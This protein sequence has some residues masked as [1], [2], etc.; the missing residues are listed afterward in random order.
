MNLRRSLLVALGIAG[1]LVPAAPASA[2]QASPTPAASRSP[3]D[4]ARSIAARWK[5]LLGLSDEQ[6]ARFEA[7]ALTAEK[8]TAEAR[9]AAAGDA[10]KFQQSMSAIFQER[11]AAVEKILTP[12]QWQQYEASMAKARK[13]AAEKAAPAATPKP[14]A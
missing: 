6:T 5:P 12:P 11:R 3:E 7:V 14:P 1:S 8:K 9:A 2:R 10:A 4:A 13:Q